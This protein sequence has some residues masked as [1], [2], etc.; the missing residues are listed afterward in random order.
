SD[1]T[2]WLS[3][4]NWE[5]TLQALA[6]YNSQLQASLAAAAK[7]RAEQG[8]M[9]QADA[10]SLAASAS[11]MLGVYGLITDGQAVITGVGP[12][13]GGH[14]PAPANAVGLTLR[15]LSASGAVLAQT[16]VTVAH[17]HVDGGNPTT[18]TFV[19]VA[20]AGVQTLQVLSGATV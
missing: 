1:A 8:G 19:G 5:Q 3:A 16:P 18:A 14:V 15:A 13:A 2:R 7:A 6:A 17:I 11:G 4:E 12:L 9:R 20:P 10:H